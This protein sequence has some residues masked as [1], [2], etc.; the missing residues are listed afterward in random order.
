MRSSEHRSSTLHFSGR[1]IQFIGRNQPQSRN[2]QAGFCYSFSKS[3]CQFWGGRAHVVANRDTSL[4]AVVFQE[5]CKR[6]SNVTNEI[7]GN[8]GF[9]QAANIVGLNDRVEELCRIHI[10]HSNGLAWKRADD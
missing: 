9:H 10:G 6:A 2:I 5:I 1:E 3:L 8:L 7:R 4:V